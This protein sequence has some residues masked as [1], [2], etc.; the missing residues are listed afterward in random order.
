ME[1]KVRPWFW[2]FLNLPFGATSGF[3]AVTMGYV[4]KAQ[5]VGDAKIAALV[6]LNTLPH[7]WKFFWSPIADTTLTRKTWYR[8]ANLASCATILAIAFVPI[9]RAPFTWDWHSWLVKASVP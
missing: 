5:G 3:V 6:A 7:T 4:L 8:I 1:R 9:E 2:F